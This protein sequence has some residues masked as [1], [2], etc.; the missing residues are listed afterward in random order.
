[1][2]FVKQM[3]F[4]AE[5]LVGYMQDNKEFV[6]IADKKLSRCF[7]ELFNTDDAELKSEIDSLIDENLKN[8]YTREETEKKIYITV[9]MVSSVCCDAI[10]RETPFNM[11]EIKPALFSTIEKILA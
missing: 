7:C 6:T 8:G 2:S 4:I 5:R 9:D 3:V 11:S 1:M 10:I